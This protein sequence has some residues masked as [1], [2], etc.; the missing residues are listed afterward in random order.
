MFQ[1]LFRPLSHGGCGEKDKSEEIKAA[2]RNQNHQRA[3][4]MLIQIKQ[5][6]SGTARLDRGPAGD[7]RLGQSC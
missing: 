1:L 5:R 6:P 4:F 3:Q 7:R 2:G